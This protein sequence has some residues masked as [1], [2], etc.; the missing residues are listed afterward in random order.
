ML[1]TSRIGKPRAFR[2]LSMGLLACVL[3]GVAVAAE[4]KLQVF[5]NGKLASSDVRMIGGRAYAPIAD[6]ASALSM[7][8]E[9]RPGRYDLV[10]RTAVR[11]AT[12]VLGKDAKVVAGKWYYDRKQITI[13]GKLYEGSG[14][15]D[16]S[17]GDKAFATFDVGGWDHFEGYAGVDDN[18]PN[19]H[20]VQ[21][22]VDLD[23]KRVKDLEVSKGDP[24]VKLDIPLAGARTMTIRVVDISSKTSAFLVW[25]MYEYVSIAEPRLVK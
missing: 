17:P 5:I 12:Q 7:T 13:A 8:V 9:S 10:T 25:S 16:G 11:H 3:A 24:A 2:V 15:P 21:L 20:V 18:N 4:R 19:N 1:T 14:T 22:A 23:G 6:I